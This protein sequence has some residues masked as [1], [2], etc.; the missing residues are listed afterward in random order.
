M[1]VGVVSDTH[2]NL[3]NVRRLVELFNQEG[4]ELVIHTGDISQPKTIDCLSD[5]DCKVIGVFG[6][7][8]IDE[9]G[10]KESIQKNE[11]SFQHPPLL[12]VIERKKIAVFHEPDFIEEFLEKNKDIDLVLHGHTHRYF[13]EK[14][15][16]VTVFNPGECAGM[17]KGK[18]AIGIVEFPSL[19]IKRIFF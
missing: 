3:Q 14:I 4:V 15:K 19:N 5:L 7:N 16:G 6:N 9:L 10:L 13:N 1:L 2:N 18:N 12:Q 17:M 11:F 8:D